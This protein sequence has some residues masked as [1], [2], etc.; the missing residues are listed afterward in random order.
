MADGPVITLLGSAGGVARAVLAV[1]NRAAL[2]S[3]NPIHA[4]MRGCTLHLIDRRRK[5]ERYYRNLLPALGNHFT[6]HHFGL[7]N[8]SRLREHLKQTGTRIV[9]DVSWADTVEIL[10]CCNGLSIS[11][12]NTAL[13]STVVDNHPERYQ[14][15]P[16]I[17]R[18]R[19]FGNSKPDFT[20][21]TAI[22]CSG[23]NP[24][25]V[26]WMAV[27]L[28]KQ[29][30]ERTPLGCYIVEHDTSFYRDPSLADP[31]T[32]YTTWSPDCFLDEAILCYP[33]FMRQHEPLFLYEQSYALEFK[34]S[35]G[36]KQFYGCLMPHEEVFTLCKLFNTEGGFIYRVNEHTTELIRTHLDDPDELWQC[37]KQ[38][39]DPA[40]A[41]LAGEDL[42]GVLLVYEEEERYMYNVLS[43]TAIFAEYGVNATYFQVACGV[44]GALATLLLDAIPQGIYYVDELL[45]RTASKYGQ[46][47]THYMTD[48][49]VGTN[50]H[51]D[52]LLL[53]RT[54]RADG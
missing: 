44:Y 29:E 4:L 17:E 33:M 43:N 38:V 21:T 1:L 12:I 11:Y 48:F 47:V 20:N 28:M 36:S 34:V 51:S 39:L 14:G 3:N 10:R 52:G 18:L 13:E 30:P 8:I 40:H 41:E 31:K 19:I 15:F 24:G 54:K 6:V 35:L 46:Y 9:I 37:P 7:R 26:Q 25:V 27:E 5:S 53:D 2:D 49:V 16:L 50:E 45:L 23:M 22:I 42:V 32:I